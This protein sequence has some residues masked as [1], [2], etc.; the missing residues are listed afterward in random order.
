MRCE[1][2]LVPGKG[3]KKNPQEKPLGAQAAQLSW[4]SSWAKT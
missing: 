2:G 3:G 4:E 1:L